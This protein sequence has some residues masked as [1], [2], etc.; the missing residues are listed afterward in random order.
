MG[1]P[2]KNGFVK[3]LGIIAYGPAHDLQMTLVDRLHRREQEDVC[4]L[5]Q[6]EP[7]FT[8]GR[9]ASEEHIMVSP[10][11]L[12]Q[13][14][15]ELVKT[16]RGGQ[17]TYHAPGQIIGY[18]IINL[19]RLKLRIADYVSALEQIMLDTVA[20][21]GI[22]ASRDKRNHGI[23]CGG[24]KL[25]SVG[26]AVRHGISYHG[27]ALNVCPDMTPFNWINP[28]GM[29]EVSMTSMVEVLERKI[30]VQDVEAV[31]SRQIDSCF[32]IPEVFCATC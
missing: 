10:E 15:I 27:F 17:V 19:R 3:Q 11:K 21:F 22:A 20:E 25:G 9:H 16:E 24:K 32:S 28:C 12:A 18:P 7:V 14:R 29:A 1:R 5:L 31:L 30:A 6:H 2:M 23:W 4:L 8:L 26:I 13:N